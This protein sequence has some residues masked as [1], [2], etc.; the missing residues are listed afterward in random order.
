MTCPHALFALLLVACAALAQDIIPV[1]DEVSDQEVLRLVDVSRP[2]LEEFAAAMG[3]GHL[4]RAQELL[5]A[6][7]AGRAQPVIPPAMAP[8]VGEG[9]SMCVQAKASPEQAETWLRHVFTLSNND[10][11]KMETYDLGPQIQWMSNPSS[12][13]SWIL[14]L[15]QMNHLNSLSGLYA[16]TGDER[17]A[18]EVGQSVLSWTRQCPRGYGYMKDGQL[19][20]S[21]MEVRNRACNLI[22]AYEAVRKSPSL[23]PA[24]HMA[25]WKLFI[26]SAR[27]LM[28]YEG[29]SYPGLIPL[30]VMFPEFTERESWFKSGEANLR[31]CLVNRTSPEGAWDTQ[32]ISYQTVSVPWSLR[33]LEFLRANPQSG[34][35]DA[36]AEMVTVQV[37]KLLGLMLRIALPNGGLP[38]VGDT[39]G[40]PDWSK[41]A[42]GPM[43]TSFIHSQMSPEHQAA[44]NAIEDDYAR[45]KA[46]LAIADGRDAEQPDWTSRAFPGSGYYVMRSD[47]ENDQARYLYLDLTP[48]AMGHAHNDALHFDLYAYGKPLLADTG[49]Y[50]LGWGYRAALHNTIEVDEQDQARGVA[51][52]PMMPREWLSTGAFDLAD[53]SHGAYERL[54]VTHRR[55]VIFLKPDYFVLCDLLTGEGN[56]KL[57]QFFHFAGPTQT[58]AAQASL[59]EDTLVA[60]STHTGTANVQVIPVHTDGLTARFA[61]AQETDMKVEDKYTREAMLGWMVTGGTFQRVKAPV[62]V[63][64]REGA[65]PQ[66]FHNVLYPTPAGATA[67]L[68]VTA[69]PVAQDGKAL[70]PTE[71][72]GF[73]MTGSITRPRYAEQE[74]RVERG[75]NLA[76]GRPGFAEVSQGQ[77]ATTSALLTDG[78]PSP[79]VIGGAVS[80]SPYTPNVLLEGRFTVDFASETEVNCVILH[81]GTWN[82]SQILYPA[83]EM[84][85]QFWD[86]QG[87]VDAEA[88]QT[89]WHDEQVSETRFRPVSATRLS[90]F[91]RRPSGGRLSL[92]EFEAYRVP[93]AELQRVAAMRAETV[94]ESFRDVC[95]ISHSGPGMRQYGDYT[96]DGE[97]AFIHADG[98]GRVQEVCLKDGSFLSNG[99]DL[100]FTSSLWRYPYCNISLRGN[101]ALVDC[102]G[103]FQLQLVAN[104]EA[105]ELSMADGSQPGG[106]AEP[107]LNISD[108]RVVLEPAQEGFAGA[109]PSALVT[110]RTDRPA[111]SQV[112]YGDDGQFAQ[113]T[114]FDPT[115]VTD[116]QVRVYFLRADREYA[117]RA[118]S[119]T[120]SSDAQVYL[121]GRR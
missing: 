89:T 5:V 21:G 16:Q 119:R 44:L 108:A 58:A 10:T 82:G 71:A 11:G 107:E 94:T 92:R 26:A 97:L 93:D 72:A 87:W 62:A 110:W 66:A 59:D 100:K 64:T 63:Y 76:L 55:K 52:A 67:E 4:A 79:R 7:F 18:L 118:V 83:E 70:R 25:F 24:M 37:G 116:H 8:G 33:S 17:L 102:P 30:A 85:V 51:A 95:L 60:A 112:F 106:E 53:L 120:S 15:N 75:A 23:T 20:K 36:M 68:S 50:F 57:E 65:L 81:H 6:H 29:V 103:A 104:G 27:E 31:F 78:D 28:T 99:Q 114:T 113:R 90:V 42:A 41:S 74:I 34:D 88:Q 13:V 86:G 48:Q 117:F 91:V 77:I 39:Y 9:N 38:N 54:G 69:L 43:L 32:S 121:P 2:G 98:Q 96:F 105:V 35:F 40:R 19:V 45:L 101:E 111:T 49:D 46:A 80:S 84:T 22:V 1:D 47:W 115:L 3:E 56:H 14:Y 12:A 109:Q 73:T 61:A